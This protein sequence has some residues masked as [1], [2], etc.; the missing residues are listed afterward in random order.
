[1]SKPRKTR[2][3]AK[4][5]KLPAEQQE[6][7]H[8]WCVQD[9]LQSASQRCASELKVT[10]AVSSVAEWM[11][12]YELRRMFSEADSKAKAVEDLLRHEFPGATAEKIAAA[13]QLVFTMEASNAKDRDAFI[14]LESLRLAKQVA[15][16]NAQVAKRKLQQMETRIGQKDLEIALA[17]EKF[18]MEAAEK[19]LSAAMRAKAD[20]INN[21][22]LSNAAKIAA[23]RA[24]A[25]AEIDELQRSGKV[26]IPK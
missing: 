1:M 14:A 20:E 21:S 19:M 9:G 10:I 11:K 8:G 3:D 22:N 5:D 25:F 18:E 2:S 6:L 13:G 23:M 12:R 17:R 7:I 4:L 15:E 26:V 16:G 24:A